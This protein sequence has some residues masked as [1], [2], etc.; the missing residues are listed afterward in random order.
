MPPA[1]ADPG[2]AA[3][4]PSPPVLLPAGDLLNGRLPDHGELT[5][6]RKSEET[7]RG[8]SHIKAPR[9]CD[10]Q[11]VVRNVAASTVDSASLSIAPINEATGKQIAFT[12]TWGDLVRTLDRV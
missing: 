12:T 1:R 5:T 3:T 6:W 11:I 2:P 8:P 10:F 4:A 9:P 7:R